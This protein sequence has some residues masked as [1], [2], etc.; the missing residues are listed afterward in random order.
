M[1]TAQESTD[2]RAAALAALTDYLRDA[3]HGGCGCADAVLE[4]VAAYAAEQGCTPW[5]AVRQL[6]SDACK[7]R[8]T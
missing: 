7:E 4:R 6:Y 8:P 5:Q 3:R 1:T 2:L